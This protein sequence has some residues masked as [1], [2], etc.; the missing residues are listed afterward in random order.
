M[1]TAEPLALHNNNKLVGLCKHSGAYADRSRQ[2]P[3]NPA[4]PAQQRLQPVQENGTI[5]LEVTRSWRADEPWIDWRFGTQASAS[6][7]PRKD[8]LF[9]PFSQA[10]ESTTRR[11][12]G[13]GLGLVISQQLCRLMGGD[14]DFSSQPGQ[15]S[16]FTVH[17]P[18][19]I[20]DAVDSTLLPDLDSLEKTRMRSPPPPDSVYQMNSF[21]LSRRLYPSSTCT[22]RIF[23]IVTGD[24]WPMGM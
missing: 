14:I 18:L 12:G 13:T 23:F 3:S 8:R 17:L 24:S 7:T 15:G 20:R 9:R 10:D 22:T 21:A 1:N 5:T 11:Y 4:Q 19:C 2:V 16:T 6:P